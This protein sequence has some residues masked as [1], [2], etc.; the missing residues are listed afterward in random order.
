M[1]NTEADRLRTDAVARDA[2]LRLIL[3]LTK[4]QY[5]MGLVLQERV[6]QLGK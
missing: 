6:R 5:P 1:L 2:M 4:R 3:E